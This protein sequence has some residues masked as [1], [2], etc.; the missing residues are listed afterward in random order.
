M[1]ARVLIVFLVFSACSQHQQASL[2]GASPLSDSIVVL[3][4]SQ[5]R[6]AGLSLG[7]PRYGTLPRRIQL[8]GSIELPPQNR[9]SITFPI[10]GIV[11]SIAVLPG[12]FVRRGQV[13]ATIEGMQLIE[14]QE[15]Y[16]SAR[17]LAE[18]AER[19][20]QRQR[21]LQAQQATS[22]RAVRDAE[23]LARQ[24]RIAA[25]ALAERLRLIGIIPEHMTDTSL[26]RVIAIR[27]P[28]TGYVASIAVSTGQVLSP[29]QR[30]V[31]LVDGSDVHLVLRAFEEDIPHIRPG[32]R[33]TVTVDADRRR[34]YSAHV[35]TIGHVLDSTRTAELHC[36]FDQYDPA[37]LRPGMYAVAELDVASAEG[38]ILP[39]SAVV[40]WDNVQYIF[41]PA[42]KGYRMQPVRVLAQ[43]ADSLLVASDN[44]APLPHS[45]VLHGAYWLLMKLKNTAAE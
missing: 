1:K 23:T 13:L 44:G 7:A 8:R 36:H 26:S 43:Q 24:R 17:V 20:Y 39:R 31:E 28:V 37:R 41:V 4:P 42:G 5:T 40:A 30:I 38:Y 35:V 29:D 18:Q 6:Y 3:T 2:D 14:L 32:Q 22:D 25:H 10:G 33:L 45:V 34:R 16:L 19:E 12:M 27:S 15:Q 21:D 9:I 11:R